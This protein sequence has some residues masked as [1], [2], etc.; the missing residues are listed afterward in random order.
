MP[1]TDQWEVS[2]PAAPW[3]PQRTTGPTLRPAEAIKAEEPRH[4]SPISR[5]SATPPKPL[6]LISSAASILK[7]EPPPLRADSATP[8]PFFNRHRP[9]PHPL[10][11]LLPPRTAR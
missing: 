3:R 8:T 1:P 6:P 10:A 9:L 11:A 2:A 7:G 5:L 4:L